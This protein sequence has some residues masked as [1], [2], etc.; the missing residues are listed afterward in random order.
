METIDHHLK[1]LDF[2]LGA[3]IDTGFWVPSLGWMDHGAG[4]GECDL[5]LGRRMGWLF[6]DQKD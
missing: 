1:I 6:G 3:G 4:V 5:C 2:E